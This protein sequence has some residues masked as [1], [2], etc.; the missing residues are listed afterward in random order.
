MSFANWFEY[1][2]AL[3]TSSAVNL[4]K[5]EQ[6]LKSFDAYL[7]ATE[8]RATMAKKKD[9][10]LLSRTG[11]SKALVLFHCLEVFEVTV[12]HLDEECGSWKNGNWIS[13]SLQP[14]LIL[15]NSTL[16]W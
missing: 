10:V 4:G 11:L 7:S 12:V 15:L 6:M 9:L 14:S 2:D 1:Y 8:A 16:L 5:M 13:S 3:P